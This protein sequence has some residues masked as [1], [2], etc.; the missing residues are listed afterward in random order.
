[1]DWGPD[2]VRELRQ[3]Y[4]WSQQDLARRL[5]VDA[6]TV[7]RWERGLSR[8]RR[9]LRARIE[10]L[11]TASPSLVSAA[12]EAAIMELVRLVGANPALRALRKLVLLMR[13]PKRIDFP[14]D[15]ADRLREVERALAEQR[16]LV[17]RAEV[18]DGE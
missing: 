14:V 11:S 18:I 7:S 6:M 1:M 9:A 15:P 5:R 4:G 10:S 17:A 8:P 2:E 13:A 3:S 12:D 16:D